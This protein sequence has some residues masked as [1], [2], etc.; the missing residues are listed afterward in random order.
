MKVERP[1]AA[2]D[3]LMRPILCSQCKYDLTGLPGSGTCPECGQRYWV[4]RGKGIHTITSGEVRGRMLARKLR[5]IALLVA[6]L[7][8]IIIGAALQFWAAKQNA[9]LTGAGVGA[10][11]LLCAGISYGLQSEEE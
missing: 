9:L 6:G 4:T 11:L 10:L 3:A 2:Y 1:A 8:L 5:T 7:L